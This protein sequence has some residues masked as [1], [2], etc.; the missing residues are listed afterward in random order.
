MPLTLAALED[1]KVEIAVRALLDGHVERGELLARKR[2]TDR[3]ERPIADTSSEQQRNGDSPKSH[4]APSNGH[5]I[6]LPAARESSRHFGR[7]PGES[8]N[9]PGRPAAGKPGRP[10]KW[11]PVSSNALLAGA[12]RDAF[13]RMG[14]LALRKARQ[15]VP[16]VEVRELGITP[17]VG[18]R[19]DGLRMIEAGDGEGDEVRPIGGWTWMPPEDR[20]AACRAEVPHPAIGGGEALGLACRNS[21]RPTRNVCPHAKG[22]SA[23][24]LADG[25]MAVPCIEDLGCFESDRAAEAAAGEGVHGF[26]PESHR[27]G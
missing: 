26:N 7:T 11:R 23:E 16:G 3:P 21:E 5:G 27:A 19:A 24:L 14:E 22:R 18:C 2:N 12:P 9:Q 1:A 8:S 13:A 17:H 10:T 25:A 20:G 4:L 15:I 6:E